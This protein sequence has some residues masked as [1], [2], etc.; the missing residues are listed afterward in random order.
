MDDSQPALTLRPASYRFGGL[1][2]LFICVYLGVVAALSHASAIP[3]AGILLVPLALVFQRLNVYRFL[4]LVFAGTIVFFPPGWPG[5][6]LYFLF[7]PD[8]LIITFVILAIL[9]VKPTTLRLPLYGPMVPLYA[10]VA[11]ALIL[12][13]PPIVNGGKADSIAFD[14][15]A[16]LTL[17]L[18]PLVIKLDEYGREPKKIYLLLFTFVLLTSL[19]SLVV[20]GQFLVTRYRVES[21]NEIFVSDAILA[22]VAL[23]SLPFSKGTK[24]GLWAALGLTIFALI[25]IQTRGLWLSTLFA[26]G[27]YAVAMFVTSTRFEI[28]TVV[29]SALWLAGLAI[30]VN[31]GATLVIGQSIAD[32]F[33]NRLAGFSPTELADPYSSMGYRLHESWAIWDER[34]FFGHGTGAT[35]RLFFTQLGVNGYIDWWAI[36]SGYFE[37]LHKFGF[38]GLALFAWLY[39]SIFH[40]GWRLA[41]K[42][43]RHAKV[44]G[45][46][47]M[48]LVINHAVVSITSGYFLR[49]AVLIW[50]LLIYGAEKLDPSGATDAAGSSAGERN[51]APQV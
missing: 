3:H 19:H 47:V 15:K 30:V 51:A 35:I 42:P 24:R 10:F 48:T 18:I 4:V 20:I 43:S 2:L 31:Y 23:L 13:I 44:F 29:R 32:L 27:F 22:T 16:I 21:W 6:F 9:A 50:I 28:R 8:I 5:S 26:L 41:R 37:L 33:L 17:L 49:W 7:T 46:L 12:A 1:K 14:L 40:R 38:F 36:H 34:T 39:V 45:I 11:Y 25:A